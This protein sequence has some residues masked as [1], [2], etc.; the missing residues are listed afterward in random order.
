MLHYSDF[1]HC[2][3]ILPKAPFASVSTYVRARL[4]AR[5]MMDPLVPPMAVATPT[6]LALPLRGK[7]PLH[8]PARPLT[9]RSMRDAGVDDLGRAAARKLR[10]LR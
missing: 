9:H 1:K 6:T 3:L 10:A 2:G 5:S 4:V 7:T 8:D